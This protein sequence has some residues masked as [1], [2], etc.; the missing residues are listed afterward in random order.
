MKGLIGGLFYTFEKRGEKVD[1]SDSKKL[2]TVLVIAVVINLLCIGFNYWYDLRAN[3]AAA[4][5]AVASPTNAVGF[6][7]GTSV[8]L[9][10]IYIFFSNLSEMGK[11]MTGVSISVASLFFASVYFSFNNLSRQ[12]YGITF[13]EMYI[14]KYNGVFER[15]K[16]IIIRIILFVFVLAVL[17]LRIA[18]LFM[19]LSMLWVTIEEFKHMA[20][21]FNSDEQMNLVSEE[22]LK[23]LRQ[24]LHGEA[25]KDKLD[26]AKKVLYGE[27]KDIDTRCLIRQI[28]RQ[29]LEESAYISVRANF[30]LF[31]EIAKGIGTASL[32]ETKLPE[33]IK[34][35]FVLTLMKEIGDKIRKTIDSECR[36]KYLSAQL[37]II[38][39]VIMYPGDSGFAIL[40]QVFDRKSAEV[41]C[42]QYYGLLSQAAGI[43]LELLYGCDYTVEPLFTYMLQKGYLDPLIDGLGM[44]TPE[45][46]ILLYYLCDSYQEL[47]DITH[48]KIWRTYL[49]LRAEKDAKTAGLYN[50]YFGLRKWGRN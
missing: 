2:Y 40:D 18:V 25:D 29:M 43:L 1:K 10:S 19:F 30:L 36:L 11:S 35:H 13:K 12:R 15:N 31:Y 26:F 23:E 5:A 32:Y 46:D 3:I 28:Y 9:T 17:S 33:Q 8:I 42:C 48:L 16:N 20:L 14:K 27:S 50:T 41:Y 38:T 39:A 24:W 22:V 49:F 37:G 44:N 6:N 7:N 47:P 21:I 45:S 4:N 34:N